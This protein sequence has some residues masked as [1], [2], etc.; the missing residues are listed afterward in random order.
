PDLN[1]ETSKGR[2]GGGVRGGLPGASPRARDRCGVNRV[3]THDPWELLRPR[4]PPLPGECK[5]NPLLPLQD[6][7]SRRCAP[8][9]QSCTSRAQISL[10]QNP[11]W[12]TKYR[13]QAPF[14]GLKA[15]GRKRTHPL[16]SGCS[17]TRVPKSEIPV[18]RFPTALGEPRP[19]WG[20][21]WSRRLRT[22]GSTPLRRF[23]I[24]CHLGGSGSPWRLRFRFVGSH[25]Q[26]DPSK[27]PAAS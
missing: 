27:L 21:S 6:P 11:S 18:L 17:R 19:I 20:F 5:Q 10:R 25:S 13:F 22:L 8:E 1:P 15:R 7:Q 4:R 12:R 9:S 26:R 24:R 23:L 14:A 16:A 3:A 2:T